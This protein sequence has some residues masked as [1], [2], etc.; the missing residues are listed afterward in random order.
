MVQKVGGVE[1]TVDT[2]FKTTGAEKI[3]AA[4]KGIAAL[5]K[6]AGSASGLVDQ[7]GNSIQTS[8]GAVKIISTTS[9]QAASSLGVLQKKVMGSTISVRSLTQGVEKATPSLQRMSEKF[10][11]SSMNAGKLTQGLTKAGSA[12]KKL[13]GDLGKVSSKAVSASKS[14]K[15]A[16]DNT[17]TLANRMTDLSK[18]VQVAL[19]PL[20]GVASRLTAI[21]SLANRNTIFIAG[22]IGGFIGLGVAISKAVKVGIDYESQM[23]I[24]ENRSKALGDS[25]GL[26]AQQ[27]DEMAIKLGEDTLTSA[28]EA[29]NAMVVLST[30]VGI[31]A[32]SFERAL[33]SAQNLSAQGLGNLSANARILARVLA[34]PG[35]GLEGLARKGIVFKDNLREQIKALA[36]FGN[37]AGAHILILNKIEEAT[38]DVAKKAAEGLKG[39]IDTLGERMTRFG[40]IISTTGGATDNFR[41][42]VNDLA[43]RLG[44]LTASIKE[45]GT[46]AGSL[47]TLFN[48]L[49]DAAAFLLDN[50]DVL[51]FSLGGAAA[52]KVLGSFIKLVGKAGGVLIFMAT[53]VRELGFTLSAFFAIFTKMNPLLVLLG[54]LAGALAAIFFRTE[55]A[56][57]MNTE[58]TENI[59]K[60]VASLEAQKDATDALSNSQRTQSVAA[61]VAIKAQVDAEIAANGVTLRAL[62]AEIEARKAA[63]IAAAGSVMGAVLIA[64][65]AGLLAQIDAADAL[66]KKTHALMMTSVDLAA[67]IADQTLV[68][69]AATA[70]TAAL[71]AEADR[72]RAIFKEADKTIRGTSGSINKMTNRLS[73]LATDGVDKVT[74]SKIKFNQEL[75]ETVE[76]LKLLEVILEKNRQIFE[77]VG[78]DEKVA[79]VALAKYNET[80]EKKIELE[81][82]HNAVVANKPAFEEIL[83]RPR[84]I[85]IDNIKQS[86][87]FLQGELRARKEG[88]K[89]LEDYKIQQQAF[90]TI[91]SKFQLLVKK[92]GP[93]E[94]LRL[95]KGFAESEEALAKYL[96]E[97]D[98]LQEGIDRLQDAGERFGNT[99]VSAFEEAVISG[100]ALSEILQGLE[101][102]LVRLIFRLLVIE[103]L[104]AGIAEGFENVLAGG[105]ETT[106]MKGIGGAVSSGISAVG[107][108]FGDEKPEAGTAEK[109]SFGGIG[110]GIDAGFKKIKKLFGSM[111]GL[112]TATEE[113]TAASVAA[114]GGFEAAK[115]ASIEGAGELVK[116]TVATLTGTTTKAGET[117]AVGSATVALTGF[118]NALIA[119][120]AAVNANAASG[121]G[122]GGGSGG[123]M[124]LMSMFGGGGGGSAG[125]NFG[126]GGAGATSGGGPGAATTSGGTGTSGGGAAGFGSGSSAGAPSGLAGGS[127]AGTTAATPLAAYGV[128]I[129]GALA[130]LYGFYRFIEAFGTSL[131]TPLFDLGEGFTTGFGIPGIFGAAKGGHIKGR[132]TGTSDSIPAVLSDGEFVVNAMDTRKNLPLLEAINSGASSQSSFAKGGVAGESFLANRIGG[133]MM[134]SSKRGGPGFTQNITFNVPPGNSANFNDEQIAG[135]IMRR[136]QQSMARGLS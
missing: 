135:T 7:F 69:G 20:S 10:K 53:K 45:T 88:K 16:A 75:D 136:G 110:K 58:Y 71:T 74:L 25:F 11:Q 54:I 78:V 15:K 108:L 109:E 1:F 79:A 81:V 52:G 30:S 29:R 119:A 13:S 129:V 41:D 49:G 96:Q 61:L 24:L 34:D 117:S 99:F 40:E 4:G 95:A 84:K 3:L 12:G 27:L 8:T 102:D 18:S 46:A 98:K 130:A 113:T 133:G 17:T 106:S 63:A 48:V 92:V 19:G 21:A 123:G 76:N 107:G 134:G 64:P 23:K 9:A 85:A 43:D 72:I 28:T 101:E 57:G 86:T 50:L 31:S 127:S 91:F 83:D 42:A 56:A 26:T 103:P 32:E 125:G 97:Q 6:E 59:D 104:Q 55:D 65:P 22:L 33:K 73:Q 131:F 77:R 111:L 115:T 105:T 114:A 14:V 128:F 2:V 100:A 90:N 66:D 47:G 60:L 36:L 121:G 70:T 132:G 82:K 89:A 39:A 5:G 44:D 68:M 51:L 122:G 94:A 120:T 118:T 124:D 62:R 35:E 38:K 93:E 37:K 87:K 80:L 126:A 116:N 112:T 67:T